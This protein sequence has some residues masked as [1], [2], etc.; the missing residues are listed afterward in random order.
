M[1]VRRPSRR[2]ARRVRPALAADHRLH[3]AVGPV[4]RRVRTTLRRAPTRTTPR[5]PAH[6]PHATAQAARSGAHTPDCTR[7]PSRRTRSGMSPTTRNSG[8][9]GRT[10]AA[11]RQLYE[12]A[13]DAIARRRSERPRARRRSQEPRDVSAGDAG[14]PSTVTRSHR[15]RRDPPVRGSARRAV[16]DSRRARDDRSRSGSDRC[17]CT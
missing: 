17:R 6:S 16:E 4:D 9:H 2:N 5:T 10:P 1:D 3:G 8:P 11:T 13:R 14:R 7:S 15:W 12:Q